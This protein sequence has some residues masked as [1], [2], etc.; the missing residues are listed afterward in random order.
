M[1]PT[2]YRKAY[3]LE[4]QK[5]AYQYRGITAPTFGN[6]TKSILTKGVSHGNTVFNIIHEIV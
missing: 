1:F 6:G 5:P 3:P 4:S 2:G